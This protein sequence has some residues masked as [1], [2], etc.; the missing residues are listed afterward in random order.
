MK[1]TI[2]CQ[3][4]LKTPVHAPT[5]GV[6]VDF[7]PKMGRNINETPKRHTLARVHVV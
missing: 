7:I 4:G 5:I 6:L 1:L 2:F 3:F